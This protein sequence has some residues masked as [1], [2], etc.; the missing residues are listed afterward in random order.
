[1][2]RLDRQ[3]FR[4]DLAVAG[5]VPKVVLRHADRPGRCPPEE[6][7]PLAAGGVALQARELPFVAEEQAKEPS[8]KRRLSTA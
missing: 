1:M 5:S 6:P 4:N 2:E 3:Y 7:T 8:A